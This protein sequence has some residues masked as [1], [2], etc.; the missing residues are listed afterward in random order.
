MYV[1][2]TGTDQDST[3]LAIACIVTSEP[4]LLQKRLE[5]LRT[6]IEKGKQ[7]RGIPSVKNLSK[8]GFHYCEDHQEVKSEVIKLI[9]QIPF[10]AYICYR[11]KEGE[12]HPSNGFDWYDQLFG[13]LMHDRLR[14]HTQS[15]VNICFEQHA[16]KVT[17]R[18]QEL[19]AIIKRLINEIELKDNTSF[20]HSP[21]V[22]SA[23]KEE[24]CLAI[25]D[26]VAAIFKNHEEAV[27]IRDNKLVSD[28]SSWQ[29][30]DFSMLR[31][32]IRVIHNYQTGEFFTRKNPFP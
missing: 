21:V 19:E 16:N 24:V 14:K 26:Y 20:Y 13:K 6:E 2:E 1:D 10:D 3:I 18:E 32:K 7:F 4:D 30:R 23:G 15:L 5:D 11:Q 22:K 28:L 27:K 31:P 9:S 17:T 8:K 25:A 12:F 29:S